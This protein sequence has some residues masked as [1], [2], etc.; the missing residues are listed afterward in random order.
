M[1]AML[2]ETIF[3]WVGVEGVTPTLKHLGR[4]VNFHSVEQM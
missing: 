4:T 1:H 2:A 3:L